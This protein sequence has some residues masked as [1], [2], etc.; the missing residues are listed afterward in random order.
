MVKIK[1]SLYL[2]EDGSINLEAWLHHAAMQRNQGDFKLIRQASI[3]SQIVGETKV[4]P[5]NISCLQQGLTMAEIL[6]DLHLDKETI[7]AALIYS[8]ATYA[9]L[10]PETINDHLGPQ[11]TKLI[12][13]TKQM[14]AIRISNMATIYQTQLENMRKMLLAMVKDM[15]VVLIKLA[16]RLTT[17][18]TL[19]NLAEETRQPYAQETLDIYAPLANRLGVGQL[20]WELEDLSLHYLEPEVYGKIASLLQERLV[21]REAYVQTLIVELRT[22]LENAHLQNFQLHGRVKHIH[23]IYRKMQQK[24]LAFKELY[25]LNAI[26]ILVNTV[27]DCYN[28]LSIIHGLWP[29]IN[30]QF[31]D[32]IATPKSNGYRSIHTAVL[33]PG[34]KTL[35]IQIRT[36][37]MHQESEHGLAAHWQYKENSQQNE[38]YQTKIAWLRQVLEWQKELVKRG[39]ATVPGLTTVLDD[40]IYVFTPNGD[41]IDLPK[42]ATPLDF[43]YHIH[44]EVGHRCRG[45]KINGAIVPLTYQLKIGEQVEI[46]T[47]KQGTPSRDW[48]NPNLGYLYTARAKAKAHHWFKNQD[49]DKHIDDGQALFDKECQRLGLLAIDQEKLAHKLHFKTKKEMLA[50]LGSG[51]LR[52][53][54]LLN[55]I[56]AQEPVQEANLAIEPEILLGKPRSSLPEGITIAGVTDLL[57]QTAGCCKPVPGDTIQGFITQGRGIVLHRN[58]CVHLLNL[59]SNKQNRLVSA[60]WGEEVSQIYPVDVSVE[61]YDRPGLVRDISTLI[62]NEKLNLIALTLSSNKLE[63]KAFINLTIEIS[64]LTSLSKVLDRIKQ[65]PNVV[66]VR[67]KMNN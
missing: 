67:R 10:C 52:F 45:A 43:A 44:S 11:V 38:S 25:D 64:N 47:T 54:Q 57:T 6:L 66:D 17:M 8:G 2:N 5:T 9:E 40:R 60:N 37:Q 56:Q 7:A 14:D 4:T 55:V 46:L 39:K 36:H 62:A 59:E 34:H 28:A 18:R 65:V 22:V 13:G 61:A 24:K 42:G 51:D 41:I 3:L 1:N 63:P 53:S 16:E 23:S 20:Q 50:A 26:R 33:G 58:D 31:D 19:D 12:E 48:L 15:R 35:E 30:G 29:P 49:Y 27:K 21:D 32:Y